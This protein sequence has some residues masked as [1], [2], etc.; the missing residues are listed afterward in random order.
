M[1][2]I[3]QPGTPRSIRRV[4]F[5]GLGGV[6]QRHLRNVRALLGEEVR[7]DAYRVRRESWVLDDQLRVVPGA[8]LEQRYAL[9]VY[10]DLERALAQ[11]PDV[12]FVTN[13][14]SLHVEVALRAARANADVFIEKPLSHSLEAVA[15]LERELSRRGLCSYVGYQLRNHPGFRRLRETLTDASLGPVLSVRAE[16]G[17]YLPGF[18]PYEDYR[19]MYAARSNLGGG[20]T[21]SQIHEID[22]LVALFGLPKRGFALGGKVSSLEVDVDDLC[23]GL[24]E[25]EYRGRRLIAELH[26]DFFQRPTSRHF[27]VVGERGRAEWSLSERYFRRWDAQGELQDQVSYAEFP[28]NQMFI[29]ELSEFFECVRTRRPSPLDVAEGGKSLRVALGLL[30]SQRTFRGVSWS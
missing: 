14:S 23:S 11:A 16:V 29:D 25:F 12:V 17:E 4:L 20:V 24:L 18:H 7:V 9:E 8:E 13:P 30:E 5:A 10:D 28:R 15:D 3:W 26:Q 1:T 6:G 2:A 21:L 22:C 19:R 27:S